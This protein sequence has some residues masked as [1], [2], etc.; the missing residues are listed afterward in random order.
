MSSSLVNEEVCRKVAHIR[1]LV[2]ANATT[3]SI[4]D[5]LKMVGLPPDL[6]STE[7]YE[8]GVF[9]VERELL[10]RE[11]AQNFQGTVNNRIERTK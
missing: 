11:L 1:I 3:F 4:S 5:A 9:R 10:R 8:N 7:S 2:P 6:A